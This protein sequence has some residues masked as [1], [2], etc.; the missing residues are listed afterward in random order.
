[1]MP[2][3]VLRSVLLKSNNNLAIVGR[4]FANKTPASPQASS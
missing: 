3:M 2:V 4:A 1:M